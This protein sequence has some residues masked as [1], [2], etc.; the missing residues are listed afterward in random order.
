[1]DYD[2]NKNKITI[3]YIKGLSELSSH[4]MELCLEEGYKNIKT[5]TIEDFEKAKDT[6]ELFMDSV[7][8]PRK[9]YILSNYD[10]IGLIED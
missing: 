5:I 7:V 8:E 6:I 2:N 9:E 4:A 3:N 10:K 1:M